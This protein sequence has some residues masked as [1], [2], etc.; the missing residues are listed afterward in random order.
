MPNLPGRIC[1]GILLT[2]LAVG[3]AGPASAGAPGRPTALFRLTDPRIGEASGIA[4]GVASPGVLYVHN[5]SGDSARFFAL[6][7]RT[8]HTLAV[9]QVPGAKN[10]DWEDIAAA[11]DAR[12]VASLW[13]ADIGDNART[14]SE[15]DV[16][17][18][19]EPRVDHSRTDVTAMTSPPQM[20]RLRYPDGAADA[21]SLA[22]SPHGA[23]YIVTKSFSGASQVYALPLRA[24]PSRV[25]TLRRIGSL[26][27]GFTATQGGPSQIGQLTATGAALSRD[28]TVL[29]VRTYTDAY[30]WQVSDDDVGAALTSRP[31]RVPLPPQPQGEGIAFDGSRLLLDSERVGSTVYELAV[32]VAA[33]PA[34]AGSSTSSAGLSPAAAALNTDSPKTKRHVGSAQLGA[35]VLLVLLALAAALGGARVLGRARRHRRWQDQQL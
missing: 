11:P 2:A 27:F 21:E 31:L 34:G 18:V 4:T 30:L 10:I 13:L 8:G 3:A 29:A 22:V 33:A 20:W 15:I 14:R 19:N 16:Y 24:D 26:H 28:G 25:Q 17:R 35:V 1:A 23:G 5:D 7:A 6:D 9:F 32:A 12:G